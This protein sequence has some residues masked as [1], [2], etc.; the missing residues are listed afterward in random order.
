MSTYKEI[1]GIKVRSLSSDPPSPFEG[2]VWY[3]SSSNSLKYQGGAIATAWATGGTKSN[4]MFSGGT[5]GIQTAALSFTPAASPEAITEE[6]DGTAWTGGGTM[7][8]GARYTASGAGTQTAGLVFGGYKDPGSPPKFATETESYDGTSWTAVNA[9][10]TAK[11]QAGG[12]GTQTAALNFGGIVTG[13]GSTAATE[14]YNGSTWTTTG[15]LNTARRKIGS[16]GTQTAGLGFGGYLATA[17]PDTEEYNG[18]SWT[19]GGDMNTDRNGFGGGAGIQTA[20][21]GFGG[22]P[23]ASAATEKYDGS[24]WSNTAS[25]ITARNNTS[26]CGTQPAAFAVGGG[27]GPVRLSSEEFSEGIPAGTRTVEVSL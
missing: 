11:Y 5:L 10:N 23:T 25:L 12:C 22:G 27:S 19:S 2:E 6:Y 1:N 26:G 16:A 4:P 9:L 24:S 7:V 15:S 13:F 8:G 18:S 14:E 3:N 17:N 20:A 21:L